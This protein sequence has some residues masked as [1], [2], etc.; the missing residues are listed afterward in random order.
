VDVLE[1]PRYYE[2]RTRVIDFLEN[3]ARQFASA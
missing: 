3:H 1:H 2:C